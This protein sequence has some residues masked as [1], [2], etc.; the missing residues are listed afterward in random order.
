[1]C[2]LD[3]NTYQDPCMQAGICLNKKFLCPAQHVLELHIRAIDARRQIVACATCA[4]G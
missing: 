4:K 3:H 1:M 2:I